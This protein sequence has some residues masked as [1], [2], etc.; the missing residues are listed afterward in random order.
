MSGKAKRIAAI[1]IG[2]NSIH[3]IVAE[4]KSR[5]YRVVDREKEMVQLGL[6]SLDGQPLTDDAME[7]G[8]QTIARMAALAKRWEADEVIAVAT[9]AVREAPNKREFLKRVR[10]SAGIKIRVISGDEEADYIFRA[11]RCAVDIGS[12]TALCIDIG[13]GS[14]EVIVGTAEEIYFTASEPLGSLRLAQRFALDETPRPQNVE[15]CR[16]YVADHLRKAAKRVSLLGFDTSVGTSGT[17]Q[18]LA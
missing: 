10:D 18:A 9:S 15:A 17:I 16:R 12:S 5:G 2:T 4:T 3:M 6:S 14:A 8:V 1:D 13:G 7:R 11:V